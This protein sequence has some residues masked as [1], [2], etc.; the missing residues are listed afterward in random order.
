M[1]KAKEIKRTQ[2]LCLYFPGKYIGKEENKGR[3]P[4]EESIKDKKD[5]GFVFVKKIPL[6]SREENGFEREYWNDVSSVFLS[7]G[8]AEYIVNCTAKEECLL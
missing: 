5:K 7:C 3:M 6:N 2:K 1:S 4:F 8:I